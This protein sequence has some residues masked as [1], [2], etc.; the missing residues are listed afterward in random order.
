MKKSWM[1]LSA[2]M[3]STIVFAQKDAATPE[4]KDRTNGRES[5][6]TVLQLDDKQQSAIEEIN[7]KYSEQSKAKWEENRKEMQAIQAKRQAEVDKV[8][9][10]EQKLKWEGYR[11]GRQDSRKSQFHGRGHGRGRH[12]YRHHHERN[13]DRDGRR[14][15]TEKKG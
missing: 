15:D 2:I 3:M 14:N 10:P 8:L 5:M 12:G 7:K 11:Q 1:I 13:G 6:K 9:T 4:A